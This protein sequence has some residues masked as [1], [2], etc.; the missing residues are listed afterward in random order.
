M[1]DFFALSNFRVKFP[2][3]EKLDLDTYHWSPSRE[4]Y[5]KHWDFSRLERLTLININLLSFFESVPAKHL[6]KLQHL[7]IIDAQDPPGNSNPIA[8]LI[9]KFF[10]YLDCL[11]YFDNLQDITL[12]CWGEVNAHDMN[13]AT[14]SDPDWDAAWKIIDEMRQLKCGEPLLKMRIILRECRTPLDRYLW[15]TAEGVEDPKPSITREFSFYTQNGRPMR[16]GDKRVV[17]FAAE[18]GAQRYP[19]RA[20]ESDDSGDSGDDEEEDE[21]GDEGSDNGDDDGV[22]HEDVVIME[23]LVNNQVVEL[24]EIPVD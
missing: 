1:L 7:K 24:H 5:L 17:K 18:F 12:V 16:G 10:S 19:R 3:I 23:D 14:S 8:G 11:S 21:E 4:Q 9:G 20:D 13:R 15:E 22:E 2:A 6:S